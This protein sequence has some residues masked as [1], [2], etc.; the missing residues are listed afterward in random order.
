MSPHLNVWWKRERNTN[1]Q[2]QNWSDSLTAWQS[3]NR[4]PRKD[5]KV[6]T[7]SWHGFCYYFYLCVP[8]CACVYSFRILSFLHRV[9]KVFIGSY[10]SEVYRLYVCVSLSAVSCVCGSLHHLS[11]LLF[12]FFFLLQCWAVFG[13]LGHFSSTAWASVIYVSASRRGHSAPCRREEHFATWGCYWAS[14]QLLSNQLS[15]G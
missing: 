8:V 2:I 7:K 14:K 11:L 13:F 5:R 15:A 3:F 4:V 1:P 9:L 6:S 10:T 12:Y